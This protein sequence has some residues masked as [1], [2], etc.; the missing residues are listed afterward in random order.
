MNEKLDTLSKDIAPGSH[1]EKPWIGV[2]FDG[3]L[4]TYDGWKGPLHVGDPV[5]LMMDRVKT[6]LEMGFRV[7]IFTARA[8]LGPIQ[9][10]LVRLWMAYYGL[11]D[12]E[13]TA[14]KDRF[15]L[16]LWDDRA[17]QVEKNTGREIKDAG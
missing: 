3:C 4:A 2:D 9:V 13:I 16:E 6:W 8:T 12:L 1:E 14:T 7:K 10:A 11:P 15:M 17:I 5:P